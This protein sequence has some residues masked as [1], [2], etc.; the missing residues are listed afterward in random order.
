M[1]GSTGISKGCRPRCG[2]GLCTRVASMDGRPQYILP[3]AEGGICP[4]SSWPSGVWSP[5]PRGGSTIGRGTS[6]ICLPCVSSSCRVMPSRVVVVVAAAVAI[7]H[8][9][10]CCRPRLTSSPPL[11]SS[12][13]CSQTAPF[14]RA[15]HPRRRPALDEPCESSP[16]SVSS[17]SSSP[18]PTLG[19]QRRSPV[20]SI[21]S[22][23]GVSVEEQQL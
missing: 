9:P 5:Q 3:T 17:S 7:S 13:C 23:P 8:V 4:S 19:P 12:P 6:L 15:A 10:S 21:Y 16:S 11:P 20:A 18:L 22:Q 14:R 1:R 2:V